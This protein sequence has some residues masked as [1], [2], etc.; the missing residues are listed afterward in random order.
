MIEDLET[1]KFYLYSQN[2]SGGSFIHDPAAG[3]SHYV[4]VQ[5]FSAAEADTRAESIGLY[6]D[7]D[8]D[9]PCCGDRWSEQNYGWNSEGDAEPSI[10]GRVVNLDGPME[11]TDGLSIKWIDGPE[12]YVHYLNGTVR[13]FGSE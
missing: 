7:G 4:I 8:G 5:A 6:F 9:C 13:G 3:I 2:N 10:Y 12:G 11:N 1:G